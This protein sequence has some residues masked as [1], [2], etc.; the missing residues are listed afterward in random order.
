MGGGLKLDG[1]DVKLE[2][3]RYISSS[4]F[5][6]PK[7]RVY[8][9]T[10]NP[11]MARFSVL[12]DHSHCSSMC[13]PHGEAYDYLQTL[14]SVESLHDNRGS[15]KAHQSCKQNFD[16]EWGTFY[17]N[18]KMLRNFGLLLFEVNSEV[19]LR[20]NIKKVKKRSF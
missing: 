8:K 3:V 7:N 6:H 18:Q 16:L 1:V 4:T 11:R 9:N 19:V 14:K 17:S 2:K 12:G 10:K 5:R 20:K 13:N 15:P